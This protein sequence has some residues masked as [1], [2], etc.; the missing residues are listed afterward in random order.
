MPLRP[1]HCQIFFREPKQT[2]R[3]PEP[4]PVFR[5][6]RMFELLLQMDESARGLDQTFKVLRVL[7]RDRI[8][9]P[10]L[11][12]NIVRFIVTLLVPALKKR[13]IIRMRRDAGAGG[14]RPISLQ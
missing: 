13:A 9:Q 4:F 14:F 3:W 5:M 10:H 1:K 2:H 7:R 12:Q 11:F 8:V 6:R